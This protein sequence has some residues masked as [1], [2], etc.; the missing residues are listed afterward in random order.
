M[1]TM[2]QHVHDVAGILGDIHTAS[3]G[4]ANGVS[5]VSRAIA[6]MDISTQQNA[7]MVEEAAAAAASMRQQAAELSALVATF[8]LRAQGPLLL[9]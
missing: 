6:E 4:Q 7:A 5:Q 9:A 3:A 8:K 1:R 2:L